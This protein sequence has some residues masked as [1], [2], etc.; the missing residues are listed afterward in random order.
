MSAEAYQYR[1]E[2]KP[3]DADSV[4]RI[5]ES[6]GFFSE[7]EIE[8]AVELVQERLTIGA[9]SGYDFVF[10]E[11]A[12]ETIGYT[13]FGRIPCTKAS[14]D[15]YW[16]AV[17]DSWRGKGIGRRLLAETEAEIARLGGERIYLDTSSRKQYEPTRGF[18]AACG[19]RQ[20]AI[21]KDFY[22][23]GDSKVIFAREIA[24]TGQ[25]QSPNKPPIK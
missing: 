16:I 2:V 24:L 8:I 12:G 3:A 13:C 19:Y 25:D 22:A 20:E 1:T 6:S 14:Y 4:R 5:V 18:Y 21:L 7:E 11:E 10:V 23:A 9:Q 15:L 17:H